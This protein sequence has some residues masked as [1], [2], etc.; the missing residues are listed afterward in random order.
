MNDRSK[1]IPQQADEDGCRSC[2]APAGEL[3]REG[4]DA[5]PAQIGDTSSGEL[6]TVPKRL[7]ETVG[8]S[9]LAAA[10]ACVR[11]DPD[12]AYH[13]LYWAAVELTGSDDP[14]ALDRLA[15]QVSVVEDA[16]IAEDLREALER[17]EEVC[18]CTYDHDP[19]S[20]FYGVTTDP[21]CPVPGYGEPED[22]EL[23]DAQKMELIARELKAWRKGPDSKIDT[24]IRWAREFARRFRSDDASGEGHQID[25]LSFVQSA[26]WAHAILSSDYYS[27]ATKI[28]KAR[29]ALRGP[30]RLTDSPRSQ[31]EYRTGRPSLSRIRRW[32]DA[33][34]EHDF[35]GTL[36][37][38]LQTRIA[39]FRDE[40]R[41]TPDR[42]EEAS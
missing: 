4:C 8:A 22:D 11:E 30:G 38:W 9:I 2:R 41:R 17:R 29:E 37:E 33:Y 5:D 32:L 20:P 1:V 15:D 23:S 40:V 35:R 13:F 34:E 39:V 26:C 28:E 27:P 21:D 6:V 16:E 31:D 19:W 36:A 24:R 10:D 25:A 12:E 7:L 42:E 14:E 3:H 18:T